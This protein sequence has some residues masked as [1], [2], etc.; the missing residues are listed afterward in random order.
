MKEDQ[1]K[2]PELRIAGTKQTPFIRFDSGSNT[3]ELK[4]RSIPEDVIGFYL[5][6]FEWLNIIRGRSGFAIDVVIQLEYLNTHSSRAVVDILKQ[7]AGMMKSGRKISV[8]WICE[9]GDDEMI[10]Y[11]VDLERVTGLS[12]DMDILPESEYDELMRLV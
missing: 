12:V 4:G 2:L 10:E 1:I 8:K 3:L 6:V 7:L 5:P 11:G 9:D